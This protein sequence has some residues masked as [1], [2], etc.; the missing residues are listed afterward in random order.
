MLF[1]E[2]FITI[3][4]VGKFTEILCMFGGR[5]EMLGLCCH[6]MMHKLVMIPRLTPSRQG[7]ERDDFFRLHE[8]SPI[9]LLACIFVFEMQKSSYN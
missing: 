5:T 4:F 3:F 1:M 9:R 6:V 2:N 8:L 7:I